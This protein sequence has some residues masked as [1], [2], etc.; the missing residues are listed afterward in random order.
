[1]SEKTTAEN[2]LDRIVETLVDTAS[3]QKSVSFSGRRNPMLSVLSSIGY[4][5]ARSLSTIFWGEENVGSI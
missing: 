1:M 5:V 4:L 3:K 2:Y